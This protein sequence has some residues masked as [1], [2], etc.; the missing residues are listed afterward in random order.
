MPG[1]ALSRDALV[2]AI[3]SFLQGQDLLSLAEIRAELE[4]EVD[5]AG[6]DA[7]VALKAR[8]A[9]A[10]SH[11]GYYAKDPLAR[12][13]HH[14]LADRLLQAD[15]GLFGFEHAVA[16]SGKPVVILAN[17]LSYS[18]ANLIEI[19][20]HRTA[21]GELADRLTTLAGPKVFAT[22]TRRF[23][24]LCFGTIKTPQ[25][26]D[27][28]SED[29]VMHP[30]EVAQAARQSIAAAQE[31]LALGDAL[32]VFGEGTRSRTRAMQLLLAGVTRY[33]DGAS[34]WVLPMGIVGTEGLFPIGDER[35][36]PV[37][38]VVRVGRPIEACALHD[39]YDGSRRLMTDAIGAAIAELLPPEY[40]GVYGAGR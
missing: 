6:P 24:S 25:S 14:V 30:R 13:V 29:A 7:L 23:S 8:L 38:V 1:N 12:R 15:S 40:R 31:R 4:R 17:H 2:G 36:H 18:D 39:R 33:L 21:A 9:D 5:G 20:L 10:A 16:V 11:W 37:R 19:L 26:A 22:R 34:T 3:M 27:V 28:S 32:L 35:L